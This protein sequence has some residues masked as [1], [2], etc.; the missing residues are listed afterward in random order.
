MDEI[1]DN[2]TRALLHVLDEQTRTNPF[3][4]N[5]S[6][7]R[8]YRRAE[9]I[10]AALYL[11][12]NHVDAS[13]PLRGETRSLALLMMKAMLQTKDEMRAHSSSALSEVRS[14]LRSIISLVRILA[15][16]GY[17][18]VENSETVCIAVDELG[19]FIAASQRS[20]LSDSTRLS[21]EDF[22]PVREEF[23]GHIKDI[24]D[25][26]TIKD[27]R[28]IKDISSSALEESSAIAHRSKSILELLG[29]GT[30]FSIRDIVSNMPEYGEKTIQRE[31]S[32]LVQ[33]GLVRR[34]GLRRWSKYALVNGPVSLSK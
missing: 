26:K 22:L 3:G 32:S 11:L 18:S 30:E 25:S 7:E 34:I 9:R 21:R 2:Q 5:I 6:G 29:T 1:K 24:K 31:L 28:A 20:P 19:A 10:V 16:A 27:N 14:C 17:I 15:V 8:A 12:T 23:K 4:D 33:R 13:E